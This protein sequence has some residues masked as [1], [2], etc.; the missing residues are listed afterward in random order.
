MQTAA[1]MHLDVFEHRRRMVAVEHGKG[2][3][4]AA[5]IDQVHDHHDQKIRGE[6]TDGQ[7]ARSLRTVLSL[8]NALRH[9]NKSLFCRSKSLRNA[10][11]RAKAKP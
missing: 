2:L 1:D 4:D 5:E 3:I 6:N 9:G 11:A 7:H 8:L 10:A